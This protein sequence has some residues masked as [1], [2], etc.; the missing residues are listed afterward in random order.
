M[1]SWGTGLVLVAAVMLAALPVANNVFILATRY[2]TRP[3]RISGAILFST[4]MALISFNLWAW[5]LLSR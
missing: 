1:K 3:N 5:L 2:E 4:A